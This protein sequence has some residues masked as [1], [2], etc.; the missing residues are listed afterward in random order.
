[1]VAAFGFVPMAISHG[2]GAEVQKP[3]AT[4]VI[5]GLISAT[6]LTLFVLP[7]LYRMWNRPQRDESSVA[8]P[9]AP[10]ATA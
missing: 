2:T 1:L 10:P 3:L 6:I 8:P 4:V 5:G 9:I 7:A